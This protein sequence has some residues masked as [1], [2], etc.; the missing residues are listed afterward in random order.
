MK[1][2]VSELTLYK[3]RYKIG[4]VIVLLAFIII[5]GLRLFYG[6]ELLSIDEM[7]S[8]IISSRLNGFNNLIDLPYRIIQ[9]LL[10]NTFGLSPIIIKLPSMIF[11]I[12]SIIC[13]IIISK[14]WTNTRTAILS[15]FA[16]I[17]TSRL[18]FFMQDGTPKIM[19]IFWSSIII[20]IIHH[21]IEFFKQKD[22][23]D[24]TKVLNYL[25]IVASPLISLSLYT[26]LTIYIIAII[27]ISVLANPHIRYIV[28][29]T[30][31]LADNKYILA[32][33]F[34][35]IAAILP[36]I[37][38]L[39]KNPSLSLEI[40]GL[41]GEFN[42]L[43]N[44]RS[45]LFSYFGF[46]ISMDQSFIPTPIFNFSS[47]II[48]I[49]GLYVAIKQ[50]QHYSK[51]IVLTWF[52]MSI[53]I[54]V[55]TSHASLLAF[56]PTYVLFAI[57]IHYLISSW[58]KIFPYNPYARIA[59][60]IPIS[61]LMLSLVISGIDIFTY[62]YRHNPEIA[63]LFRKDLVLLSEELKD[64]STTVIVVDTPLEL[65]FYKLLAKK[66]P[67]LTVTDKVT[68]GSGPK[69]IVSRSVHRQFNII[70][71]DRILVDDF[72]KEGDRFYVYKKFSN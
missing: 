36:L 10:I 59:G 17:S 5:I 70:S 56:L 38:S 29:K 46:G 7:R 4:A 50:R 34:A 39:T 40:L 6:S 13:L 64:K 11:A 15:C 62:S 49:I 2:S 55:L 14:L 66:N 63:G 72:M 51:T 71:I 33:I 68:I 31:R 44:L 23:K 25:L 60:L 61:L 28:K 57:G 26:P 18:M 42:P 69:Q 43:E 35:G 16:A 53:L 9:K 12:I 27:V 3:L 30:I 52:F 32:S 20:L 21:L 58:Y 67:N 37:I 22:Y 8:T 48:V 47:M 41:S 24:K 65:D 54:G 45:L 19:I 1:F